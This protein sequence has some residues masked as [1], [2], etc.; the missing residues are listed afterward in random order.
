[1]IT[2]LY[3]DSASI[4]AITFTNKAARQMTDRLKRIVGDEA[5]CFTG[6]FHGKCN[7]IL[8]EEAH[9]LS[10]PKAFS[11]LD[12]EAQIDLIRLVAEEQGISLKENTARSYMEKIAERKQI[13]FL[14][15]SPAS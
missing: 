4:H 11:I 2:N 12:K 10:Y 15:V 9:R 14:H 13:P 8:K 6:T 7:E 5:N 1:M 3:I